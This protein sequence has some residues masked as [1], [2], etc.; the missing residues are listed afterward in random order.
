MTDFSILFTERH[1]SWPVVIDLESGH[2]LTLTFDAKSQ[3]FLKALT[4]GNTRS[5]TGLVP[6]EKF[7]ELCGSF[8]GPVVAMAPNSARYLHSDNNLA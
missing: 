4:G 6:I 3:C 1:A 2:D 7:R 5:S 8:W